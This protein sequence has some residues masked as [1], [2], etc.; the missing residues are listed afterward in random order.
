[1]YEV[2]VVDDGSTDATAAIACQYDYRLIRTENR[3]L[4]NARNTGLKAA[5]GEIVAYIDDDAYPDP[6]W[7]PYL[8]ARFLSTSHAAVGGPN[9]APPGDGPTAEC[10][11]RAPRAPVPLPRTAFAPEPLPGG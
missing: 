2:I 10:V 4:A 5:T 6:H 9:L 3:G 11:A 1:D 8:A 7:L